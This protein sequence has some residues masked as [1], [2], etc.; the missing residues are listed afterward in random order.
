MEPL[1]P[2]LDRLEHS[3]LVEMFGQIRAELIRRGMT[4]NLT[5]EIGELLAVEFYNKTAGLTTLSKA[6]AGAT[7]FDAVGKD[8]KRYTIKTVT[9]TTTSAFWGLPPPGSE[10]LPE[11]VF[12]FVLLVKLNDSMQLERFGELSWEN[13]LKIKRWN[14]RMSAWQLHVGKRTWDACRMLFP[15]P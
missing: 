10:Q 12:D 15:V 3:Q 6:P 2:P 5:G 4:G 1:L 11:K 7:N 13:F 9:G 14:K 8:G